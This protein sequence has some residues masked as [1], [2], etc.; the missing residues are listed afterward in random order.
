[1]VRLGPNQSAPVPDPSVGGG[2]YQIVVS[3]SQLAGDETLDR[4]SCQFLFPDE[5]DASV[6][7][8][9]EGLNLLILRFPRLNS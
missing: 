1:M 3:G 2:Q 9:H 4:L 8:T 7:A 6:T 5:V